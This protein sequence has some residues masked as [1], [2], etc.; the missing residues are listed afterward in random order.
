MSDRT[1]EILLVAVLALVPGNTAH[2]IYLALASA[3][4][5]Y[6]VA[7]CQTPAAEI[8]DLVL[9]M[10]PARGV[11]GRSIERKRGTGDTDRTKSRV[12]VSATW[13]AGR[14]RAAVTICNT[15]TGRHAHSAAI[16]SVRSFGF[17]VSFV[18]VRVGQYSRRGCIRHSSVRSFGL[19]SDNTAIAA[20]F[21]TRRFIGV[22]VVVG[23]TWGVTGT[24]IMQSQGVAIA[25]QSQVVVDVT[26]VVGSVVGVT[27][28]SSGG[29]VEAA[30]SWSGVERV[31]AT[32]GKPGGRRSIERKRGTGDTDRTKGPGLGYMASRAYAR[33]GHYLQQAI[34]AIILR[35]FSFESFNACATP[36][37]NLHCLRAGSESLT[38]SGLSVTY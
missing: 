22:R 26:R 9:Y 21:G 35:K 8:N 31:A 20:A 34:R 4:L 36:P 25:E 1:F 24:P 12:R 37:T 13:L 18:R 28:E 11:V 30:A 19:G 3:S 32:A 14:T 2:Y 17:V 10:K 38:M 16:R 7:R 15:P 27:L 23:D 6:H 33:G 5:A 29:T